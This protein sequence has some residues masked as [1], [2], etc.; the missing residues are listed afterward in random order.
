VYGKGQDG[1]C[2]VADE[3]NG[4]Q[5][6]VIIACAR[7]DEGTD[8]A[9]CS[10][11][12]RVGL[13]GSLRL[14]LQQWGRAMRL[15]TG[16]IANYPVEHIDT[17]SITFFIPQVGENLRD[18]FEEHHAEHHLLLA[19]FMASWET[20]KEYV[21]AEYR[22]RSLEPKLGT[23]SHRTPEEIYA[24]MVAQLKAAGYE[25]DPQAIAQ[26]TRNLVQAEWHL[27]HRPDAPIPAPTEADKLEWLK[28]RLDDEEYTV[29]VAVVVSEIIKRK[30]PALLAL[31]QRMLAAMEGK[32]I[33][34]VHDIIRPGMR[35]FF[36]EIKK[37]FAH[38]TTI[39]RV[40]GMT[41]VWSQF[42]G[43]EM[44][45]IE[46]AMA[47]GIGW[48]DIKLTPAQCDAGVRKIIAAQKK[49]NVPGMP[50]LTTDVSAYFDQ[51]PGTLVMGQIRDLVVRNAEV[52]DYEGGENV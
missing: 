26:A 33:A 16:V 40:T 30:D 50:T 25:H 13:P 8:W 28:G 31:R 18:K 49:A 34:H 36:E 48:A 27:Q 51:P 23:G 10:H 5:V 37:E 21:N 44:L 39:D 14:I 32:D 47:G 46:R 3:E 19:C 7:F 17:A 4:S 2:T 15:K 6:D 45:S 12:Y 41:K 43:N 35:G 20:G 9:L 42:D 22:M 11:V 38:V 1:G 52:R 24:P 29:A